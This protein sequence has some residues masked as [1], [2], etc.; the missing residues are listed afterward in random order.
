MLFARL[1][2]PLGLIVFGA[3]AMFMGFVVLATSLGSGRIAY[4]YGSGEE[5][6]TVMARLAE[7]PR[8]FWSTAA[9]MGGVPFL[10]GLGGLWLGRRLM[11]RA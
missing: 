8:R 1:I 10:A 11:R 2:V 6:V 4:S 3:S 7:E 5:T 9:V